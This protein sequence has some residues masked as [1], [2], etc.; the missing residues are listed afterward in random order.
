MGSKAGSDQYKLENVLE[1]TGEGIGEANNAD[2][3]RLSDWSYITN[4]SSRSS[5]QNDK[6]GREIPELGSFHNS[7]L[8]SL[9][10][11]T[12]EE[13][14]IDARLAALDQKLMVHSLKNI[15]LDNPEDDNKK[16]EGNEL[17]YLP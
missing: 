3:G 8:G 5:P 14:D 2:Y 11:Y 13:D 4:V 17:E 7:E 15:A 10:P 12:K 1:A 6:H 9:I 16:M